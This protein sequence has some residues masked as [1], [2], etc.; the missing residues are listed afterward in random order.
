VRILK[1][2]QIAI[3]MYLS[4]WQAYD[5]PLVPHI[6]TTRMFNFFFSHNSFFCLLIIIIIGYF[7][8]KNCNKLGKY[9]IQQVNNIYNFFFFWRNNIYNLFLPK[10][11]FTTCSGISSNQIILILDVY[12]ARWPT[13][14]PRGGARN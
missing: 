4:I 10:I 5:F 7:L 11:T 9:Q 1:K 14:G 6:V 12:N 13:Y 3:F 8:Q 2:K